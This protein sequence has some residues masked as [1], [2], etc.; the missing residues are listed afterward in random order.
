MKTF[1]KQ[2]TLALSVGLSSAL[3]SAT[4]FS[5]GTMQGEAAPSIPGLEQYKGKPVLI[6]FWASWCVPCKKSF[7]FM[8]LLREKYA[9]EKFEIIAVNMDEDPRDAE[10]FL[11]KY[12]ASFSVVKGS[13]DLA[14][15]FKIKGLPSAY[16]VNQEGQVVSTHAGFNA[17]KADKLLKQ[18]DHLIAATQ[19]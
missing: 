4:A 10:S 14:K 19:Q 18:I 9:A 12:P 1:I 15:L 11:S 7:P 8:N 3:L 13:G 16:L 5:E 2:C 6:D 17:K